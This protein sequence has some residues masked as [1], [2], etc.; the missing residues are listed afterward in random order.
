MASPEE[1]ERKLRRLK[2]NEAAR[3]L[4]NFKPKRIPNKK[5]L[6]KYTPPE[7]DLEDV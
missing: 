4:R 2:R 6:E 5:K 7:I 3:A 1:K